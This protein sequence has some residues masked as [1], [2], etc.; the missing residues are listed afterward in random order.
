M[1]TGHPASSRQVDR[2]LIAS[3]DEL[4]AQSCTL[5]RDPVECR[6]FISK[7]SGNGA[8]AIVVADELEGHL[9]ESLP[10]PSCPDHHAEPVT[11]PSAAMAGVKGKAAQ[12]VEDRLAPVHL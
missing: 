8:V 1:P 6:A 9:L 2:D 4:G 12:S 7:R 3:R 11:V 5:T 10:V